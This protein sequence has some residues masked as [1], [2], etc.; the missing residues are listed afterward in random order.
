M[1]AIK[2]YGVFRKAATMPLAA[3]AV[4]PDAEEY[5]AHRKV[6]V[7]ECWMDCS[8]R[9][10][11]CGGLVAIPVALPCDDCDLSDGCTLQPF[12]DECEEARQ[13]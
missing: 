4:G 13:E 12:T 5:A 6:T 1:D 8:F 9:C 11:A 3:F 2:Y 7:K 10:P